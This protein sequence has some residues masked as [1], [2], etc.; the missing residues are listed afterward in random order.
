MKPSSNSR[1]QSMETV[2]SH[3]WTGMRETE[4]DERL[5]DGRQQLGYKHK[6]LAFVL[7]GIHLYTKRK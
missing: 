3:T 5:I 1:P 2:E 6:I 7:S 4:R